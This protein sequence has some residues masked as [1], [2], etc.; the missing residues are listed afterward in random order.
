MHE[1]SR[2]VDGLHRLRH[3]VERVHA[4]S[5]G[6]FVVFHLRE[7]RGRRPAQRGKE[8]AAQKVKSYHTNLSDAE[9]TD[10]V[11]YRRWRRVRTPLDLEPRESLLQCASGAAELPICAS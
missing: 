9:G 5:D 8:L 3:N 1:R 4:S 6:K 10:R 11:L 7:P 2:T